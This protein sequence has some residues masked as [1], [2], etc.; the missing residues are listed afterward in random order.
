MQ[1]ESLKNLHSQLE[2]T[3][4]ELNK[5]NTSKRKLEENILEMEENLQKGKL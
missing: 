2:N 4:M 1:K 3:D 5:E